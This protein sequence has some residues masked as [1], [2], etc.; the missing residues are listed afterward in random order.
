MPPLT[1]SPPRWTRA[2]LACV[3]VAGVP[4]LALAQDG[5]DPPDPAE[6]TN[7]IITIDASG[8]TQH[9]NLRYGPITYEHP[10]PLGVH[11]TVSDLTIRAPR[12]VL[13]GPE[14]TLLSQAKGQRTATF[15][16]EV[17]ATRRRLEATGPDL[18][19]DERSGLGTMTGGVAIEIQPAEDEDDVTY[20]DAGSVAFD[21]D[22]DRSVSREQV[23]LTVGPQRA[24]ADELTYAE[25][26]DLGQLVC[27]DL[28]TVVR[29]NEDGEP[30]RIT[31]REIRVLTASDRL[32]ARGDVTV[33]DGAI[34]SR[35]D[36]VFYDDEEQIA[37]VI[38]S[39]AT[40]VDEEGG[41]SLE[42]DRILQDVQFDF[43]EAIDASQASD[44]E[45]AD[46]LFE[47]E[48][49]EELDEEAARAP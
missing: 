25:T 13:A 30:M 35:G 3:L 34:T 8:G 33:I 4:Y 44:V 39:P 12:A 47:E 29:E 6:D 20:I 43:V 23:V 40:A 16:G 7:R 26:R 17:V 36:E 42:S 2:L 41:V 15:E 27:E 49:D 1:P 21:V 10:D 48:Q 19:Y 46:F 32:W 22:T 45:R 14:D 9:G 18:T 28:C 31:A 11:A 24:E 37:E 38:G 5:D